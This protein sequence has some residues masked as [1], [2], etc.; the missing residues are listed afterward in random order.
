MSDREAAILA[1]QDQDEALARE[2]QLPLMQPLDDGS[3]RLPC[4]CGT[5]HRGA[6]WIVRVNIGTPQEIAMAA[7]PDHV[8]AMQRAA[9]G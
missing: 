2:T 4:G 6:A 3:L 9:N 1:A 5:C 7:C 8:G